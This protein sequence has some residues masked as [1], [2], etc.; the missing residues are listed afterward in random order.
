MEILKKHSCDNACFFNK[1]GSI[2]K[3]CIIATDILDVAATEWDPNHI[4]GYTAQS[5]EFASNP[6]F[7]RDPLTVLEAIYQVYPFDNI[8]K[9]VQQA[10]NKL[11]ARVGL[12]A[13]RLL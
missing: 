6:A 4:A 11:R 9:E 5:A 7:C 13:T 8:P 10:I 3:R 12:N 1:P 2:A